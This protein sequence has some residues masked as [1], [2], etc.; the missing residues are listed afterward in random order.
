MTMDFSGITPL[1]KNIKVRA[2]GSMVSCN[3]STS[4]PVLT[5]KVGEFTKAS[6]GSEGV[7]LYTDLNVAKKALIADK[8]FRGDLLGAI[9]EVIPVGYIDAARTTRKDNS[10]MRTVNAVYVKSI[11][12]PKPKPEVDITNDVWSEFI[13][14]ADGSKDG[15]KRIKLY[16]YDDNGD[17]VQVATLGANGLVEVKAGF[18]VTI[19]KLTK[20]DWMKVFK[21]S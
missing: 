2:D 13:G 10:A 15:F 20:A 18:K 4:H 9:L 1:Y 7:F 21:T 8:K 3:T 14:N 19:N 12:F 6:I 11:V 5:Y 16:T 17:R